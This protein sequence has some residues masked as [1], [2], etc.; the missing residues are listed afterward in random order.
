MKE[1]IDQV[2]KALR[3]ELKTEQQKELTKLRNDFELNLQKCQ[4]RVKTL[5][6]SRSQHSVRIGTLEQYFQERE[7]KKEEDYEKFNKGKIIQ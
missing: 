4:E 2:S 1:A 6:L 7:T 3:T 5:E